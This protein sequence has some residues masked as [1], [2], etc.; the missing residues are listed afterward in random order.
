MFIFSDLIELKTCFFLL[1]HSNRFLVTRWAFII[2]TKNSSRDFFLMDKHV[3][4]KYSGWTVGGQ[5]D[6]QNIQL[7]LPRFFL[8]SL[9]FPNTLYRLFLRWIYKKTDL[10]T[11]PSVISGY[12]WTILN[13]FPIN[14]CPC[15]FSAGKIS[16]LAFIQD[17]DGYWIEILSP[18]NMMSIVS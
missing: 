17:P 6:K 1:L 14:L 2:R 8:R 4:T 13:H 15:V 7:H 11:V 10:G 18:N 12:M 5:I 16:G 9:P 3:F